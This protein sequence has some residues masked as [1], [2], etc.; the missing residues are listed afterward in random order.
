[1]PPPSTRQ[2]RSPWRTSETRSGSGTASPGAPSARDT[3]PR[4]SRFTSASMNG[5]NPAETGRSVHAGS[6]RLP[7]STT[8][9]LRTSQ[10]A[11]PT[12]ASTPVRPLS[13]GLQLIA[14]EHPDPADERPAVGRRGLDH[15]CAIAPG[16]AA[17]GERAI[18]RAERRRVL[19]RLNDR[20]A[21]RQPAERHFAAAPDPAVGLEHLARRRDVSAGRVPVHPRHRRHAHDAQRDDRRSGARRDRAPRR[22]ST[23]RSRRP[24]SRA[25]PRRPRAPAPA[26]AA[27]CRAAR[28]RE[29]RHPSH[30]PA[31]P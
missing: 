12:V 27:A 5:M 25:P 9:P 19:R 30:R 18:E 11:P 29:C 16:H 1:M 10:G 26:A 23:S 6:S 3:S 31:T 17:G 8:S 28:S 22:R 15:R 4:A 21:R 20:A 7:S 13:T 14:P 24:A 2:S